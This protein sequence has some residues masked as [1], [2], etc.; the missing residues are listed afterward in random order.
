MLTSLSNHSTPVTHTAKAKPT[1]VKSRH[2]IWNKRFELLR[3]LHEQGEDVNLPQ[4]TTI[5]GF[6]I[7]CWIAQQR[8][9]YRLGRLAKDKCQKL[10]G[11][12]LTWSP[13]TVVWERYYDILVKRQQAGQTFNFRANDVVDGLEIG[14]WVA[15]QRLR[16][17]QGLLSSSKIQ[18]LEA[19]GFGWESRNESK[20]DV[21]FSVLKKHHESGKDVNTWP[22]EVLRTTHFGRWIELQRENYK[23]GKLSA[24]RIEKLSSVGFR[25]AEGHD[26]AWEKHFS[27]LEKLH[28]SGE[29]QNIVRTTSIDN[30]KIGAW[31]ANQRYAHRIGK[32]SEERITRLE[33]LGFLFEPVKSEWDRN[34]GILNQL[35]QSGKD[36][37]L[38]TD[39]VID[40]I[41]IGTW[42]ERQR[43]KRHPKRTRSTERTA[44][45]ESIGIKWAL[46]D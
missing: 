38:P 25:C 12:G 36:V 32:L 17:E 1:K 14:R 37:N 6:G 19:I 23:K 9:A 16:C 5:D 24:K 27:L 13:L 22:T 28:Q 40:G 34:F 2:E 7:G 45:L 43:Y 41:S 33:K 11:V 3:N 31:V 30:L 26:D 10:E 39:A 15:L 35:H 44:L 20:W 4:G 18:K 8:N 29:A 42:I 21:N 46:S